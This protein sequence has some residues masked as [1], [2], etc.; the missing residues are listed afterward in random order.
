MCHLVV[1]GV[2]PV[3]ACLRPLYDSV[4][5][6]GDLGSLQEG[7]DVKDSGPVV[8]VVRVEGHQLPELLLFEG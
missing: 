5:G 8:L 2:G 3:V 7:L 1:D 4:L 6:D